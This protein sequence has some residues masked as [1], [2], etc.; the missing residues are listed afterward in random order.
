[1]LTFLHAAW[2]VLS[3]ENLTPPILFV[4]IETPSTTSSSDPV[5]ESNDAPVN[6]TI[7]VTATP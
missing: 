1:M 5:L 4:G 2:P 6:V 7:T 3:S